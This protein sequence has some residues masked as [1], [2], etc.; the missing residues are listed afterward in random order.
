MT[1][2]ADFEADHE[3]QEASDYCE[4]YDGDAGRGE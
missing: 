2:K 3:N 1:T 4:V